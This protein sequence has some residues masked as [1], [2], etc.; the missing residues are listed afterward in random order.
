MGMRDQ[1]DGAFGHLGS[2]FGPGRLAG[3]WLAPSSTTAASGRDGGAAVQQRISLERKLHDF[4]SLRQR[5]W[6]MGGFPM[7][8][9]ASSPATRPMTHR[10]RLNR[11][12]GQLTCIELRREL[13]VKDGGA[14]GAKRVVGHRRTSAGPRLLTLAFRAGAERPRA[15][16]SAWRMHSGCRRALHGVWKPILRIGIPRRSGSR[17]AHRATAGP[18]LQP[19]RRR[20]S[21][22]STPF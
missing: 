11:P 12:A 1:W 2:C 8:R 17:G 7:S 20:T 15:V 16:A 22:T 18:R 21:T 6:A 9:R 14:D 10:R 4:P 5:R 13:E 19:G 3:S